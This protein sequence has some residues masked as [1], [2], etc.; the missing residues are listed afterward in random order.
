MLLTEFWLDF[1][2]FVRKK[3]KVTAIVINGGFWMPMHFQAQI[4]LKNFFTLQ[5][6]I[7]NFFRNKIAGLISLGY[8]IFYF[9]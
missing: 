4:F 8:R 7:K 3:L 6:T 2:G 5:F 1:N 9:N